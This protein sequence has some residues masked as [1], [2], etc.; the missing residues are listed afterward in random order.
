MPS[1]SCNSFGWRPALPITQIVI[2][3][4]RLIVEQEVN[5]VLE[6]VLK[7]FTHN[8]MHH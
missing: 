8:A 5:F 1:E 7:R 4:S 2:E 6:N 3:Y